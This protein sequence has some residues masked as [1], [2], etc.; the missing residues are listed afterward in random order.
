[1]PIS[2]SETSWDKY[3]KYA[4]LDTDKRR[5]FR[6]MCDRFDADPSLREEFSA[7]GPDGASL[8]LSAIRNVE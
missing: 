2:V 6:R 8:L 3:K 7:M 1:M 5:A 4:P